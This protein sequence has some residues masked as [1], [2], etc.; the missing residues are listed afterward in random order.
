MAYHEKTTSKDVARL[1]VSLGLFVFA[2]GTF[3]YLIMRFGVNPMARK[4]SVTLAQLM[5]SASET[6]PTLAPDKGSVAGAKTQLDKPHFTVEPMALSLAKKNDAALEFVRTENG[7]FLRYQKN[8]YGSQVGYEP[9]V[10][11][12]PDADFFPWKPL[13]N[14]PAEAG[15]INSLYSFYSSQDSSSVAFVMQWAKNQVDTGTH[16]DVY[17]YNVFQPTNPLRKVHTFIEK[18][19]SVSVP[20]IASLSADGRYMAVSLFTCSTCTKDT[21]IT[22]V[23][24]TTSG[25]YK[26]I[27]KTAELTWGQG[28]QYQYKELKEV[29]CPNDSDSKCALDPQ[30][31][32]YKTGSL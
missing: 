23:I 7:A 13:V 16:Y 12:L 18:D 3:S 30:F 27:G 9:Q 5:G 32:E 15:G 1:M 6:K 10:V 17:V 26:D 21:A 2:I 28:G 19:Q 22:M 4:N 8:V 24:D 20:K 14:T 11:Q 31:L 29:P 25:V